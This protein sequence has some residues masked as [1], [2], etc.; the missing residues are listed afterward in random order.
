ML[1]HLHKQGI[2]WV[3]TGI[4][5]SGL[6]GLAAEEVHSMPIPDENW[7][8]LVVKPQSSVAGAEMAQADLGPVLV[9]SETTPVPVESLESSAIPAGDAAS[10]PVSGN[11]VSVASPAALPEI[12]PAMSYVEAYNAVP[13]NRSEYE[14]NPGYRHEAAMELMFRQLRPTTIV[15]Q[16]NPRVIRYPD[17]YQYP[18]ARYPYSRIDVRPTWNAWG[19]SYPLYAR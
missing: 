6:G 8:V 12:I 2:F 1:A 4:L 16:N 7:K 5:T 9:N 10:S 15:K 13:F 18:Y 14:A 17:F 3:L 19:I 11:A